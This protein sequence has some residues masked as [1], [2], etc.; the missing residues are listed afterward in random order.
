MIVEKTP[1]YL[2]KKKTHKTQTNL[3]EL[4]NEFKFTRD[5]II[6]KFICKREEARL[7]E[8]IFEKEEYRGRNQ[9]A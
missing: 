7:A 9:S 3:L 1:N 4:I 5:K 6:L 2:Q 8:T